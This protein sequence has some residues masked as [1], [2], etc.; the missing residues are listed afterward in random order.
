MKSRYLT[1]L[2]FPLLFVESLFAQVSLGDIDVNDYNNPKEFYIG[3]ITVSGVKYL[4]GNVLVMLSGLTVGDKIKVPTGDKISQAVKKLWDQGLFEDIRISVTKV[5]D[6]QIF[7]DIYLQERPRLSKFQF[8]GIKKSDADDIRQKIRLVKG[9]YVTDNMI[10]KTKNIIRKFYNDKGFLNAE[11]DVLL[12]KDSTTANEV[13]MY[14]NIDKNEKV[15]VYTI[16][17]HGNKEVNADMVKAAFKKTKEKSIFNPMNNLDNMVV[18][19][20]KTTANMDFVEIA[21]VVGK[22]GTENIRLRIFKSSKFIDEDYQEDKLLL[23]KKYNSLGFRDARIVRDSISK[24]PDNTINI[25]L[26]IEEGVKYYIRNITW[27]GN[28]KYPS[29]FLDRI[30]KIQKGDVYDQDVLEQALTYNPN[31][32]D[33]RSLYMDDGYLFFDVVPVETRVEN[34]SIDLEIRMHEG[35]QATV[36]KVT[37]KG[38]TKTNDHVAL[39]ETDTRPGQLFSRDRLIRSQRTLAQLK[40]FDAEK[41]TPNVNPNPDDGTVDIGFDVTETSA[42]QIELSGGWGYG[43]IV[44]TVGLSFNNFSLRNIVNLKA[45]RPIP[46]GDGQKLSLRFQT[47]GQGYFS[48][49]FS[50]TEPWMG[51]RKP[52]ALSLSYFHSRYTNGLANND[53][54]FAYFK[55]DGIS[56][57]LGQRLRW[58]D[59]YFSL[60]QSINYNR[61]NTHNYTSIFSFGGGNGVYNA[62]SYGIVLSRNSVDAPIFART[63]SEISINLELTPPYSLFRGKVDYKTMDPSEKYKWVEYYK[64]KFKGSWYID[65]IEKLVLTPRIQ[66]GYLGAYNSNLGITPFERFYLGGDGLTGYNNMDGRELIG[67]RGYINNSLTPGYPNSIGGSVYTKYTMELRYPVSLNPS[68][69]IYALTFVEAGNDWFYWNNFNPFNVYRSV[70]VGVRVFLPMF[71]LLGLDWGYGLDAVPGVPGANGGQFHFSINSSID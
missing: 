24:N 45:W 4:D 42:D 50:F 25:D 18:E 10:I 8:N 16:N 64:L 63:G 59:D 52:L 17:I 58:P 37:I 53:V 61:Y 49:S 7:L 23:I 33:I 48:Y 70:G 60:Y 32:A 6:N 71:G 20:V 31:G 69:T 67:M 34:D 46:A 62:I 39:R 14:I 30:L 2:L 1:L 66:F 40:Y 5:V 44:G 43:R 28:T 11:V 54:G 35:K 41:L 29:R 12:K 57:G 47:Y 19:T 15:K 51:G 68:A 22:Q 36:N 3:G 26:W 27:V 65:L 55:I 21:N 9:D 13:T 56:V 38:N